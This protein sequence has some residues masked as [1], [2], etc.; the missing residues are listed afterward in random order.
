MVPQLSDVVS[1]D[2][3]VDLFYF[4]CES[5]ELNI[6]LV[7]FYATSCTLAVC[8]KCSSVF[9]CLCNSNL[10]A[11]YYPLPAASSLTVHTVFQNVTYFPNKHHCQA[12]N[13]QK[14]P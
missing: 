10:Q 6:F 14:T 4:V 7:M 9:M 1:D 11:T 3:T 13:W 8:G 5:F 2:K 12:P